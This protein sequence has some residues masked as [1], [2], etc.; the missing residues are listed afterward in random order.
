MI[1]FGCCGSPDAGAAAE[2]VDEMEVRKADRVQNNLR[3][4]VPPG[5]E[6]VGL[7]TMC[8]SDLHGYPQEK[9]RPDSRRSADYR[10][11]MLSQDRV[12][13]QRR[14]RGRGRHDGHPF[15]LES[16]KSMVGSIG[17]TETTALTDRSGATGMLSVSDSDGEYVDV[18]RPEGAPS[19][20]YTGVYEFSVWRFQ[21]TLDCRRMTF[22]TTGHVCGEVSYRCLRSAQHSPEMEGRTGVEYFEGQWARETQ[23]I[24]ARGV[25]VS[26]VEL[27]RTSSTY[28]FFLDTDCVRGAIGGNR[29]HLP[30]AST[31]LPPLHLPSSASGS[32]A[33]SASLHG[34]HIYE[35][36]G[37]HAFEQQLPHGSH[38]FEP[39][40]H[41]HFV[42]PD[43]PSW[44]SPHSHLRADASGSP[45]A[46]RLK[47]VPPLA[48]NR[49]PELLER[50]KASEHA[51]HAEQPRQ[52][53]SAG[54][55][56]ATSEEGCETDSVR[57]LEVP[58]DKV[59]LLPAPSV[60]QGENIYGEEMYMASGHEERTHQTPIVIPP[61]KLPQPS[62]S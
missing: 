42:P 9:M 28:V 41:C 27:L 7:E 43:P 3:I 62:P 30:I 53:A 18:S 15:H 14:S 34:S 2:V 50:R 52:D 4:S 57:T 32:P 17:G 37:A 44:G 1:P 25:R 5:P 36:H 13:S 11:D 49:V 40:L 38:M 10:G 6:T 24:L 20:K 59:A 58:L 8:D 12:L 48:L 45:S 16:P 33:A 29:V 61:L 60:V 22:D 21:V 56:H 26:D 47:H 35:P 23:S 55:V 51:G 54:P 31:G 39:Q 46:D 19:A